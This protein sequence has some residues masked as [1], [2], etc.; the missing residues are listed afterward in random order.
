MKIRTFASILCIVCFI[1]TSAGKV[2]ESSTPYILT[3]YPLAIMPQ[4]EAIWIKWTGAAR[5]DTED[6]LDDGTPYPDSGFVYLSRDPGGRDLSNY[7]IKLNPGELQTDNILINEKDYPERGIQF[8]PSEQT[9]LDAGIYY[10]VT[11]FETSIED[12]F[13]GVIDTTFVSNEIEFVVRHRY[14]PEAEHP[15]GDTLENV[16]PQFRWAEKGDVPYYH[17]MVLEGSLDLGDTL[18]FDDLDLEGLNIFWQAVTSD[19]EITY[20]APDPSGIITASPKPL[21]PDE[22]YT[23]I[24]LNN[25][26]NHPAASAVALVLPRKFHISGERMTIPENISPV[27]TSP[28]N[29]DTLSSEEIEFRWT[30]LDPEANTYQLYLYRIIEGDGISTR[31]PVWD[32]EYSAGGFS[33][34]TAAVTIAASSSLSRDLYSWNIIVK[35]DAGR[36]T[37]G[38]YSQFFYDVP[39]GELV[40]FTREII[41]TSP[42]KYDTLV[43]PMAEIEAE[44]LE[45]SMET[46][47]FFANDEGWLGRER[48]VG[49]M[50]L[51][52]T[53]DGYDPSTKK[54]VDIVADSTSRVTLYLRRPLSTIYGKVVDENSSVLK[55]A[56]ITAV[57]DRGDTVQAESDGRGNYDLTCYEDNWNISA[58]KSGYSSSQSRRIYVSDGEDKQ[59]DTPLSL[60]ANEYTIRGTV[61]NGSGSPVVGASVDLRNTAGETINTISSTPSNGEYAF[62]VTSGDYHLRASKTGFTTARDSVLK[63]TGSR[64]KDLILQA[65]AQVIDGRIFG[66]QYNSSGNAVINP[67]SGITVYIEDD[68]DTLERVISDSYGRFS[69]SLPA[70][71]GDDFYLLSYNR[72]GYINGSDTLFAGETQFRDTVQARA[73]LSGQ[74][75]ESPE[76]QRGDISLS[77]YDSDGNTIAGTESSQDGVFEFYNITDI[78]YLRISAA[79]DGHILDSF[80][81]YGYDDAVL[82]GTQLS[83][84]D[85]RFLYDGTPVKELTVFMEEGSIDISLEA[86]GTDGTPLDS[87]RISYSVPLSRNINAGDTLKNAGPGTYRFS[88]TTPVDSL[89]ELSHGERVITEDDALLD[90]VIVDSVFFPF[91]YDMQ[92][93]LHIQDHTIHLSCRNYTPATGIDSVVVFFRSSGSETFHSHRAE[94]ADNSADV[95]T[96]EAGLDAAN[97]VSGAGLE[98]YFQVYTEEGHIYGHKRDTRSA[99]VKADSQSISLYQVRPSIEDALIPRGH[100]ITF[101][102]IGFY[103]DAYT[104]ISSDTFNTDYFQLRSRAGN[105]SLKRDKKTARITPDTPGPDTLEIVFDGENMAGEYTLDPD[106]SDTLLI[107]LEILNTEVDS[108]FIESARTLRNNRITNE[109]KPEFIF[110]AL[111]PEGEELRLSPNWRVYP[112]SAGSM[113]ISGRFTPKSD[114]AGPVR[115]SGFLTNTLTTEYNQQGNPLQVRHRVRDSA[116]R[117]T[118]YDGISLD[119]PENSVRSGENLYLDLTPLY[120]DNKVQKDVPERGVSRASEV[121]TIGRRGNKFKT[122][123]ADDN[124][125]PPVDSVIL[126]VEIP[127]KYRSKISD[128]GE[129]ISLAAWNADSLAWNHIWRDS[130]QI[131]NITYSPEDGEIHVPAGK[132]LNDEDSLRFTLVYRETQGISGSVSVTPTPF[133]PYVSNGYLD[134]IDGTI[135]GTCI[136]VHTL[137]ST[138]G[139][140]PQVTLEIFSVTGDPVWRANYH[141]VP[142]GE[143]LQVIWDGRTR[144]QRSGGGLSAS[145]REETLELRGDRMCRNGRYYLVVTIDDGT[146]IERYRQEIILFK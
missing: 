64:E 82:E 134:G 75:A 44:I 17:V 119:I 13:G 55:E 31:T 146:N 47:V 49:T 41:E 58:K 90:E 133:S 94:L 28:D 11:G 33:G 115:I 45:G 137:N 68:A 138:T 5:P 88:L 112:D 70:L 51:H 108:V 124:T 81:A 53:K 84:E 78:P 20:G 143:P 52:A 105:F 9:D 35:D 37:S 56:T 128:N 73:S 100:S 144:A 142:T 76:L 36:G 38:D 65:G 10:L 7:E 93:T 140:D 71:I 91:V 126:R 132:V 2:T 129:N 57:S 110:T 21:S 145:S 89:I 103:G 80:I 141:S 120:S 99:H 118:N 42:D 113:D 67:I 139:Q 72:T 135:E 98:Y 43:V 66:Q 48:P 34:D 101:D 59:L 40:V 130:S 107:P 25:Y 123:S 136:E 61:L 122:E 74:V 121:Y 18:D 85:G 3:E 111:N 60:R 50:R 87:A 39:T 12:P 63:L 106:V 4:D 86:I 19:N 22:T 109:E 30:N 27:E 116:Q 104:P 8:V 125:P 127:E 97:I 96:Y 29:P 102:I 23:W 6:T 15:I 26:G 1:G 24:V 79:G 54:T 14:P 32:Q 83:V 131:P 117:I 62:S 95:H 114:F 77:L 16:T 46:M 69:A 92:D